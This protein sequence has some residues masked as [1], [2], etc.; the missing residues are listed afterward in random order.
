ME[1]FILYVSPNWSPWQFLVSLINAWQQINLVD[2]FSLST[3]LG[4]A[5]HDLRWLL[6][7][8]CHRAGTRSRVCI[9]VEFSAS[10]KRGKRGAQR[11]PA[12]G[13]VTLCLSKLEHLTPDRWLISHATRL[14]IQ[15]IIRLYL[16]SERSWFSSASLSSLRHDGVPQD[17][18][19][20]W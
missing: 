2:S 16:E 12:H 11:R 14:P 5:A 8:A 1:E 9:R 13:G 7:R 4:S 18:C 20:C 19:C 3:P 17:A 15:I 6:F 10:T